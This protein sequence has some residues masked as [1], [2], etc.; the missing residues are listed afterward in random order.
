MMLSI[1]HVLTGTVAGTVLPPGPAGDLGAISSNLRTL[2]TRI[3]RNR[4]IAGLHYPSLIRPMAASSLATIVPFL[5]G[6]RRAPR[7]TRGHSCEGGMAMTVQ[8]G[9]DRR[10]LSRKRSASGSTSMTGPP[11]GF[12]PRT[13][14]PEVLA[15]YGIPQGR[16]AEELAGAGRCWTE[17]F[18]PPLLFTEKGS[19]F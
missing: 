17:M 15:K 4:E 12:D 10:A 16:T 6:W 14:E 8:N 18:S 3:A 7:S 13:A 5:T 11:E 9:D 19:C 2:A 1:E